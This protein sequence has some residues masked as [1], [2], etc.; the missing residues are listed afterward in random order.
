MMEVGREARKRKKREVDSSGAG[1]S[2][3]EHWV[4][5][6]SMTGLDALAEV[7]SQQRGI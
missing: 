7:L 1:D 3:I 5:S 2:K 4:P 6:E